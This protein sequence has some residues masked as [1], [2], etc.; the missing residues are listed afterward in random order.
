MAR[1][2][3]AARKVSWV[4]LKPLGS[5]PPR[6]ATSTRLR[7]AIAIGDW[8]GLLATLAA[9][10]SLRLGDLWW[11]GTLVM[12]APRW[13]WA[14]LPMATTLASTVGRRRSLRVAVPAL[15]LAVG[16]VMGLCVP[17]RPLSQAPAPALTLRILSCNLHY[18]KSNSTAFAALLAA[19][20]PDVVALQ[21]WRDSAQTEAL[22]GPDWYVHRERGLFLA[23]R[24]PIARAERLGSD[25]AGPRG[26]AMRYELVTPS[27]PVTVFNLHLASPRDGLGQAADGGWDARASL[28][29]NSALRRDQLAFLAGAGLAD[30][31]S[32]A[33]GRRFQYSAG[34]RVAPA[35]SGATMPMPSGSRAGAGVIRSSSAVRA[36]ASTTF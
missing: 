29:A 9:W 2:R 21:E 35:L 23:S 33:G 26:S 17:W 1:K 16:P 15:A 32:G 13:L 34:E 24:Q 18:G 12:F 36:C 27:G 3:P 6:R 31:R 25:S 28:K 7:T 8:L 10:G 4:N 30:A 22:F 19:A 20:Q 14:L 5:L 11:P